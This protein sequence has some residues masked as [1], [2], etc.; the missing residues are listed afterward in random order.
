MLNKVPRITPFFWV[1]MIMATTVG[2]TAADLM[3][4]ALKLSLS[5]ISGVVA[6]L[7][8]ASLLVQLR[9]RKY[10]PWSYWI[11]V[12]LISIFGTL[13][14]DNLR[15]KT[16]VPL[17]VS[18]LAFSLI[19]LATLAA[20]F[21]RE[22]TLSVR[23]INTARR[24]HLYWLVM[25]MTFAL[26]TSMGDLLSKGMH[27]GY[28]TSAL[29]FAAL[30]V[31][32]ATVYLIFQ[33]NAVLAFWL[34]FVLTRPLGTSVSDFLSQP[35]SHGGMG[36]GAAGTSL[37]FLYTIVGLVSYLT[38]NPDLRNGLT[39]EAHAP[40]N[41]ERSGEQKFRSALVALGF[42]AGLV[43][44][45]IFILPQ[46]GKHPLSHIHGMGEPLLNLKKG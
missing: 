39:H 20:W 35:S 22:R 23:T 31:V 37:I 3:S 44:L 1:I 30:I 16:Q 14:S 33:T 13:I 12:V 40:F 24:E 6:V 5:E 4:Y 10:I 8:S 36:F 38:V 19:L 34:A 45:F 18:T 43:A 2:E 41:G 28:A 26:G 29:V 17:T 42:T 15:D 11:T 21:A 27:L 9:A 32:V 7:L 25:L 46:I